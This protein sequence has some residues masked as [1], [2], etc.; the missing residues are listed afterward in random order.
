MEEEKKKVAEPE[1]KQDEASSEDEEYAGIEGASTKKR[2]MMPKKADYRMRAHVN[3]LNATPFPYPLNPDYVNWKLHYPMYFGGTAEEN[4]LLYL[5]TPEFEIDYPAVVDDSLNGKKGPCVEMV[6]VGCG[7][8]GLLM[9]LATKFPD[10]LSLGME[11]RD[12]LVNYVGEKIAVL[13]TENPGQYGNISVLRTNAM[14]HITNYFRK[15]Q[16]LKLFFCF[17]DPHFKKANHRRRIINTGFLNEYAYLLK[18]QGRIYSITDIEE[19][20]IW[21]DTHLANHKLFKKLPQEELDKDPCIE[22]IST[23]TEEGKR[24]IR[25]GGAMYVTVYERIQGP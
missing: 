13:R 23:L 1:E 14:R 25:E 7:Y 24:V 5:N 2:R 3:P 10:K 9:G 11:I 12:K 6:D 18:P 20:H 15:G 21:N 4:D 8:G 17:A 16:L 19:L 22:M